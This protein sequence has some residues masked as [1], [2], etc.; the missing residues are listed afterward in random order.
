MK[1][2]KLHLLLLLLVF[3]SHGFATSLTIDS[4]TLQV[5]TLSHASSFGLSVQ[6]LKHYQY[7]MHD[8]LAGNWYPRLTPA[9]VLGLMSPSASERNKF[10]QIVARQTHDRIEREQAFTRAY[11][12][13][14]MKLYPL[15]PIIAKS[16]ISKIHPKKHSDNLQ[17][18]WL[19]LNP[20]L[21][22]G[23]SKMDSLINYLYEHRKGHLDIYFVGKNITKQNIETWAQRYRLPVNLIN[24]QLTLNMGN[25]RF[26]QILSHRM[27]SLPCLASIEHQ[28]FNLI[29]LD[30]LS[31]SLW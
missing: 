10:A 8:T 9:E 19:F 4:P 11:R 3:A 26:N 27:I 18:L 20:S 17:H 1:N 21:P 23:Q 15:Q 7:L 2:C 13:A 14:Y 5:I 29:P 6:Q 22:F 16:R 25:K 28:H 30:D 12:L 31:N 24:K